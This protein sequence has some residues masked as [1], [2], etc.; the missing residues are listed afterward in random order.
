MIFGDST[1]AMAIGKARM[2]EAQIKKC[3][4]CTV[5]TLEDSPMAEAS[6]RMPQLTTSLLQRFGDKW[7][8]SLAINDLYYDFMGP[9]LSVGRQGGRRTRRTTSRPATAR[10]RP[11]SASAPKQYQIATVPEP[12]HE[13]G[14]QLVDEL[15][16]AFAKQ[17]W[18]GYVSGIHLVTADNIAFDGGP[19]NVFDPD[20]GYRDAYK[21]IWGVH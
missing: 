17:P 10:N 12:L 6:T 4:G 5:L 9:S 14:W 20:N 8:Y 15:N 18:S 16:R 21:K 2:M 7:T 3:G 11:S 1:Y 19:K 13:Q